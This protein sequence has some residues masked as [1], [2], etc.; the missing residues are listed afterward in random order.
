MDPILVTVLV[1]LGNAMVMVIGAWRLWL[2]AQAAKTAAETAKL[3]AEANNM[4]LKKHE[5]EM[6]AKID[7]NTVIT[8]MTANRVEDVHDATNGLVNRLVEQGTIV[9]HAAGVADE[10]K[11]VADGGLK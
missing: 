7:Q 11:R 2:E 1:G 5:R 3:T 8:Q 9:G 4:A 10:K 6:N